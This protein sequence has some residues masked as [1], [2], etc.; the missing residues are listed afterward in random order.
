MKKLLSI[1]ITCG[2]LSQSAVGFC[3]PKLK[4]GIGISSIVASGLI[5]IAFNNK[6]EK[7]AERPVGEITLDGQRWFD[8][9]ALDK[10]MIDGVCTLLSGLMC[11]GTTL[12]VGSVFVGLAVK[13]ILK[14]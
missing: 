6:L 2:L 7:I 4:L 10:K 14:K 1:I 3:N 12:T 13:D 5:G 11:V 8:K 9:S